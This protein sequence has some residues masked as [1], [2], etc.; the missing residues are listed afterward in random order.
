MTDEGPLVTSDADPGAANPASGS[1]RSRSSA[2]S[3]VVTVAVAVAVA[4]VVRTFLFQMFWIPSESMS[5][6]LEQGDR[7]IV[8]KVGDPSGPTRGDVLVFSRPPALT[9]AEDNL[10]KRVIGLP[11]DHIAFVDG[12]VFVNEVPLDEP[13]LPPGTQTVD[14]SSPGCAL[15]APCVVGSDELWMMGDNRDHS[16]DSRRFGPIKRDTVVGRAFVTVWPFSRF[17]GL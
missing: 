7:V 3:W 6:T 11:G 5:P 9:S 4:V 17:G 14:L 15:A 2:V 12:K 13:Y 8:T 16:A 1:R 10:I